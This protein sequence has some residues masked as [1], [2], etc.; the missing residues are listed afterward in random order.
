MPN[1]PL[2]FLLIC[3]WALIQ[4]VFSEDSNIEYAP[5]SIFAVQEFATIYNGQLDDGTTPFERAWVDHLGA[6]VNQGVTMGDNFSANVGFGGVFQFPLPERK[7]GDGKVDG[8]YPSLRTKFF[9]IG[10]SGHLQ[11]KFGDPDDPLLTLKGGMFGYKYNPDAHNLGEYLFRAEAY[12][13]LLSSGGLLMA[14]QGG[15]W[16]RGLL[17][18]MKFGDFNLDILALSEMSMPPLYN[19]SLA[20]VK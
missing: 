3:T 13:N 20:A 5:I 4:P 17:G 8:S 12:P 10:P 6:F 9:Y 15:A 2:F 1:K 7:G 14:N 11:Y 18:S 16:V 19:I